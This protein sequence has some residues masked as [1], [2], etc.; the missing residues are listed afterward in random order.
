M[1]SK[2]P[3]KRKKLQS[4]KVRIKYLGQDMRTAGLPAAARVLLEHYILTCQAKNLPYV[5]F[6]LGRLPLSLNHQSDRV[7]MFVK[8]GGRR[9][10]EKLKPEVHEFR[11]ALAKAM[12]TK[13]F[14]W[15][16]AGVTAAVILFQS[17]FWV[18]GEYRVRKED[19]DNKVKPVLDAV[20]IATD[21]PDELNWQVHAFKVLGKE[22]RTMVF[23]F[24]LGDVVSFYE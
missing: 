22:T 3:P 11:E 4:R 5:S 6:E 17:P 12:G 21:I 13:R 23:L 20:E 8:G 1:S 7:M 16:P 10:G 15:K 19:A 18:T 14:T 9:P 2:Q 24:D